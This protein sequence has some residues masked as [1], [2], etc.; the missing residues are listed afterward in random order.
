D[1]EHHVKQLNVQD[2]HGHE[3]KTDEDG[4]L[5][6]DEHCV[7][8]AAIEAAR[9]EYANIRPASQFKAGPVL[10]FQDID[11]GAGKWIGSALIVTDRH[12]PPRLVIRDATKKK[13]QAFSRARL[14]DTWEGNNFYRYDIELKLLTHREKNI[15]YWFETESGARVDE[16]QKW[17]FFVP[18]LD[19]AF[20]WAF[21]S[22]NGFTSDVEDP[23]KNFKGAN[24][25]WD[26]LLASHDAKPFHALV[27]GGDQIYND[28]V[29]DTVEM[30]AWLELNQE[31]RI[32]TEFTNDKKYAVEKYYFDHY[33]HHFTTDTYSK[34]LSLIPSVNG[35]DDHDI[36]DGYGSYPAHYQLCN[37]M[38]G[39][40]AAATRFYLL[41]QHH[42]NT[43]EPK[44]A[45]L[46]T[47]ASGKGYNVVTHFN[48]HTL[49]VVPDTR[50]ERSIETILSNETFDM[51]E[52]QI[53]T[54]L[55]DSTRHLVIV[56][57][58]PLVYPA[59]TFMEETLQTM[60]DSLSRDSILGK[61]F[62]KNKAFQNVLG[63]F[64]PELLDDL[65]DSWACNVHTEEKKRLVLLLQKFAKERGVRVTFV[66]GDV[67][68]GGAGRLFGTNNTTDPL[69][70]PLHMHQIVS[71]AI[72]NGPPPGTVIHALHKASKTYA[73]N[74]ETSEE[75]IDIFNQ[76]VD[77][78]DL[79]HKKLLNRRNW[80]EVREL[81]GLELEFTLHVENEDH[82]GSKKFPI[83]VN[84]LDR[85]E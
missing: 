42:S 4:N 69:R 49:L 57:G 78:K 77:G 3:V 62:G 60:G 27:G 44:K 33:V 36:L 7:E 19:E 46:L 64:G 6:D 8:D 5:L 67:H 24:P 26:D 72:V 71:S 76:D 41:F 65:V 21:Y 58:T 2:A 35:W 11:V 83:L 40:G 12:D 32:A 82:C 23:E 39:I 25:L 63:Q 29:L 61:V 79:E 10:R 13:S 80:C 70:D 81:S 59:L 74:E 38:Q 22:C 53:S 30:K 9:Q 51:L 16:P 68:V 1:H 84:R 48:K 56:L 37:V 54:R 45:D 66:G 85:R 55:T 75:M 34:A 15:E 14:L 20:N 18:A 43:S 73:L 28:E 17:N 50:S 47:G 31:Q 52:H